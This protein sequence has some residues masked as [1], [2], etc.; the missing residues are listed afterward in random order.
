MSTPSPS[1][2]AESRSSR[3]IEGALPSHDGESK[4]LTIGESTQSEGEK[5]LSKDGTQ[6]T[7]NAA[8]DWAHDP[9][10]PLN[11]SF[12]KKWR[13]VAIVCDWLA[14]PCLLT[15]QV[16]RSHSTHL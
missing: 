3:T 16:S 14:A 9:V 10:N 7:A 12:A 1:L 2:F 6:N 8:D 4:T 11:W 5:I 13:T 15:E